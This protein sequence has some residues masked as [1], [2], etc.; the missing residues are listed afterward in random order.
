MF[1]GGDLFFGGYYSYLF[2]G[3]QGLEK[4][5]FENAFN[6]TEAGL[7]FGFGWHLKP[8]TMGVTG[9]TALT[10]FTK[11]SNAN[12]A[13]LRNRTFYFTMRYMF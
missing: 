11:I 7:T 4:L 9:R 13:P 10:D 2:G 1:F 12:K 3:K 6:R 5:D 8:F